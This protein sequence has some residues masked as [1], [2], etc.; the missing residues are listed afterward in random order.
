MKYIN[1]FSKPFLGQLLQSIV[2]QK[3]KIKNNLGFNKGKERNKQ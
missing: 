2:K 3:K 1:I